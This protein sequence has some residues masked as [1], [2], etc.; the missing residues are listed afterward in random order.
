[1]LPFGDP[2]H[3]YLRGNLREASVKVRISLEQFHP[4]AR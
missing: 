2:R 1:M 4:Q 3:T